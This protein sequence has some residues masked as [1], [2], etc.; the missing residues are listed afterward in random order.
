[1]QQK[2]AARYR[3]SLK[4]ITNKPKFM[5]EAHLQIFT[6]PLLFLTRQHQLMFISCTLLFAIGGCT[7][8]GPDFET[9]EV[10]AET[11][12]QTDDTS[13]SAGPG[14]KAEWWKQFNDP[15]LDSLIQLAYQQ[16][17][18]LQVAGLRIVE[19]R[20]RLGIAV[21]SRYP[22][23]QQLSGS[24]AAVGLSKNSPNFFPF[25]DDS[26]NDYQV[27]FDAAWEID[28][29]GRFSRGIE[30]AEAGLSATVANYD[31]A[32]VSLTAE[33]ARVYV[34]IRTLEERLALARANVALQQESLRIA[35]VRYDNGA[36]TELDVQQATS[37][38]AG[39]QALIPV[40]LKSLRQAN[41]GLSILLGMPP[42]D[43]SGILNGVGAIPVAPSEVTV[44][45]PADLLRRRPDVRQAE[46]VAASQSALI[47]VA[48]ADL[49]PSFSLT[50]FI[51]FQASN[52][53][54]SSA[55]DMLDRDSLIYSAGPSFRWNILN[56]GRLKNNVRIQ[57]AR[58]Q[59]DLVNYR[60]TVLIA[61][62][63]VE[64]AMV[65]FAQSQN[66]S[67]FLAV[68]AQAA[69]R[70]VEIANI[71]YRE[72]SADFQRVIDSERF[73]VAQQDQWT[74]SKGDIALNLIAMYKALGGGWE[75]RDG[76]DF[77]SD[78]NRDAMEQRTNWGDLLQPADETR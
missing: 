69:G 56:Y 28:F 26:F 74:S 73:L 57:D 58:L 51:G 54:N 55:G 3:I 10:P 22:Q 20:A 39:T 62:Q 43:L 31:N 45:I 47:G 61:Y 34:T 53:G 15:V 37:N 7:T 64:D 33:V 13:L 30:A 11:N 8:L 78:A 32:L 1:M 36:T 19:E 24:A 25:A 50:G 29:W 52:T 14:E 68:S 41:H 77:I 75:I 60:N 16:N 46:R 48:R 71:Q 23:Q 9:P 35:R 27:G 12:W 72:G 63:E 76:K 66:Q 70:A 6:W 17:L 44:G 21:G 67:D 65:A 5:T 59:Q 49:F 40:L 38:L 2:S 42:A 4:P 18:P